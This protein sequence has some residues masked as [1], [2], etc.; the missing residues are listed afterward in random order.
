MAKFARARLWSVKRNRR[1]AP[2]GHRTSDIDFAHSDID[3][4]HSDTEFAH[5]D[6]DFAHSDIGFAHSD[7][8][9]APH[10]SC[11]WIR[12]C[13]QG[14]RNPALKGVWWYVR[15]MSSVDVR[16]AWKGH[17]LQ[18]HLALRSR[19]RTHS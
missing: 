1:S 11:Q 3:F 6:I 9:F 5:S 7:I 15:P 10:L 8:D 18:L 17:V 13:V 12:Y 16:D 2:F 4:A 14:A 19:S